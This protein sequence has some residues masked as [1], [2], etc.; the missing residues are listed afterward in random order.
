[1]RIASIKKASLIGV[2][3]AAMTCTS[4]ATAQVAT[5][6]Q[7]A[8]GETI[9]VTGFRGSLDQALDTKREATGVVDV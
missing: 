1:M 8:E 5:E 3:L 9:V 6:E 2:S 7:S 4:V